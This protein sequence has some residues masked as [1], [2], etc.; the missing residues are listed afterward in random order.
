MYVEILE[1]HGVKAAIRKRTKGWVPR[2]WGLRH[3]TLAEEEGKDQ[4]QVPF[5][6]VEPPNGKS[7]PVRPVS[8]D[9]DWMV[10]LIHGVPFSSFSIE[11][12]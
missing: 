10:M 1:V 12:G 3:G 6:G 11:K 5:H 7:L 4:E 8:N 2:S 9:T